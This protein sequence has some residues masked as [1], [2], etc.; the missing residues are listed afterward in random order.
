MTSSSRGALRNSLWVLFFWAL[1]LSLTAEL[2]VGVLRWVLLEALAGADRLI[3]F[4]NRTLT[5]LLLTKCRR[6]N[7]IKDLLNPVNPL[8]I[9]IRGQKLLVHPTLRAHVGRKRG[10]C[11]L[12]VVITL[13]NVP[14]WS[15]LTP[16]LRVI[17][18]FESKMKS[19]SNQVLPRVDW[20]LIN[21]RGSSSWSKGRAQP[22]QPNLLASW[23]TG[24]PSKTGKLA[25][26]ILVRVPEV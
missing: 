16:L 21:T 14:P 22:W 1:W 20:L 13:T 15:D 7:A 25:N 26:W 19:P 6:I 17:I 12:E 11:S 23:G 3:R 4:L 9:T 10:R 24:T 18:S 2:L 8:P 5:Q